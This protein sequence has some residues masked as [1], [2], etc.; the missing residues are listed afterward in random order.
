MKKPKDNNIDVHKKI[1]VIPKKF[2][3]FDDSMEFELA[4][5]QFFGDKAY[6]IAGLAGFGDNLSVKKW[7]LKAIKQIFKDVNKLDTTSRHKEMMIGDIERLEKEVKKWK[8]PWS[9][10]YRLFFLCSR[11]LGY[12]YVKGI[13][14][15]TPFYYQTPNQY[16]K[17]L[18]YQGKNS[19]QEI[20]KD[21]KNF[22]EKQRE[23]I[24]ILKREHYNDFKIAMILN[25][26]EY[27]IK[28]INRGI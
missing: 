19:L 16:Y 11:F 15:N 21:E 23:I 10:I 20:Q 5:R 12:D 24:S 27:E 28:K 14:Y 13:T 1:K 8:N 9:I 22:K 6:Q 25:T 2:D 4:M 3:Y 26:S 7:L 18:S 17:T